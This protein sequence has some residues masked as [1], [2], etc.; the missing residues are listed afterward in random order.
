MLFPVPKRT[1]SPKAYI[2]NR[3]GDE[4]YSKFC[5]WAFGD[6]DENELV[7]NF[8]ERWNQRHGEELMIHGS[9]AVFHDLDDM[10]NLWEEK[11]V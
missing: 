5:S 3:L 2:L 4:G 6:F 1:C 8:P 10:M 7:Q 11:N 9:G